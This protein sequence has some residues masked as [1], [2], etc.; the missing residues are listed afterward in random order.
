MLN[1]LTNFF[2]L[3]TGRRI[4][5]TLEDSDLIAIGT[6]QSPALG[7]Y[8][9]TAIK[10][11]DLENQLQASIGGLQTVAVDGVTITGNGTPGNPLV[12]S[13]GSTTTIIPN[14]TLLASGWILSGSYY[15]YT[16]ADTQILN[17]SYVTFVPYNASYLEVTLSQMTTQI[18]VSAGSCILYSILP[19]QN[20]IIGDIIIQ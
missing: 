2:N 12:A 7:D 4:K 13:V 17:T 5:T 3:I 10:F 9:P 8:K 16:F 11:E 1:N 6:K 19:P 15:Q 20:D 14:V 18:S